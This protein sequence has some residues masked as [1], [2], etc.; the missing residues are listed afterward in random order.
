M[1]KLILLIT[2]IL[3]GGVGYYYGFY[4][5]S[6]Y[7]GIDVSHHNNV[8]WNN[9]KNQNLEFCYVKATEG[10]SFKDRKCVEHANK[11]RS[12]GLNVGLYHYYRTGVSAEDQFNNFKEMYSK[13]YSNLVP[14]IDVEEYGND[15]ESEGA[16]GELMNLIAMFKKEFGT[17]PLIYVGSLSCVQYIPEMMGCPLW[18]RAVKGTNYIPNTTIKQTAVINHL[19][20]NYCRNVS[21]LVIKG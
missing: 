13:T 6:V 21:K 19:D 11:A 4:T 8:N 15:F 20:Y 2:V 3:L 18:L 14:A 12:I 10:K 9:V 7:N 16:I 17:A 1:K 5:P